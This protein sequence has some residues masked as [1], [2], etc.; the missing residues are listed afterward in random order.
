MIGSCQ[1]R[2]AKWAVRPLVTL[3]FPISSL[4]A[5][6]SSMSMKPINNESS[7]V[8]WGSGMALLVSYTLVGRNAFCCSLSPWLGRC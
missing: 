8:V 4:A 3:G 7:D 5:F 2:R 6:A 1:E